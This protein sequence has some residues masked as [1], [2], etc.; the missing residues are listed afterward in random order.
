MGVLM[1]PDDEPRRPPA[2]EPA[3]V[4]L[5]RETAV[6]RSR[7]CIECRGSG[8]TIRWIRTERHPKGFTVAALCHKCDMGKWMRANVSQSAMQKPLDLAQH[9]RFQKM[10]HRL[11]KPVEQ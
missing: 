1:D 4:I 9:P 5:D 10:F 3:P 11:A 2:P 6:M 8:Q 7:S